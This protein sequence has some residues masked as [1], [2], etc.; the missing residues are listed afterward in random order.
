MQN[1]ANQI[2]GILASLKTLPIKAAPL[3]RISPAKK[4]VMK[5]L[6][7]NWQA[8]WIGFEVTHPKLQELA[9]AS[10][11]FCARLFNNAPD[12]SLLV[13]VGDY[14][15]GKSHAAKSIASYAQAASASSYAHGKWPGGRLPE[16]LFISWPEAVSEFAEKRFYLVQDA[17]R[18]ELVILD[19]IGSENDPWKVGTEKLVQILS[20]RERM[21]TVITTNIQPQLWAE[22][23][24]G[25]TAD[26][27][28]R[29]SI[30]VNLAGVTSYAL[31]PK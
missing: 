22:M 4:T 13:I 30:V 16:T 7:N 9:D 19:D 3:P 24:D 25:R 8:K 11:K 6:K 23:F 12:K 29:N 5:P 21:F 15:T 18:A 27:L 28:L 20:R 1:P 26:R 2:P 10:E 31:Q 17:M 14:G